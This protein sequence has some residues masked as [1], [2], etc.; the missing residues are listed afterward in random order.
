MRLAPVLAE[1][2][3]LMQPQM[4]AKQLTFE[5]GPI[6]PALKVFADADKLIQIMLNLL[7]NATKFTPP[8]GRV[9]VSSAAE[10][11]TVLVHV[12]DSGAGIPAEKFEA[13]FE[14]FTQLERKLSRTVE[15]TGLGLSISRALA[16]AMKG[17]IGVESV[18]GRGST[19]TL[20]LPA[21]VGVPAPST[22]AARGS[23]SAP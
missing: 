6:D 23:E 3:D 16:R 18:R 15:G 2:K 4:D 19:F 1:V 21:A 8:G 7:T 17:D 14:P 9:A 13:I 11:D 5:M 10:G 20:Q 22:S 12:R